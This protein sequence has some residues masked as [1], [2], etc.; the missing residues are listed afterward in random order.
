MR[1]QQ[2]QDFEAIKN[3]LYAA[4][5]STVKAAKAQEEMFTTTLEALSEAYEGMGVNQIEAGEEPM[6]DVSPLVENLLA[7]RQAALAKQD[8]DAYVAAEEKL[9]RLD[10][11]AVVRL[12]RQVRLLVAQQQ[13]S[14]VE[15]QPKPGGEQPKSGGKQ[16]WTEATLKAKYKTL[17]QVRQA[18]GISARTWKEAVKQIS[19]ATER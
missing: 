9:Q 5:V 11:L 3:N 12:E 14:S 2:Q 15:Q 7:Q 6:T 18:F 1:S 16:P 17:E 10:E 19:S 8:Y 13:L 4:G